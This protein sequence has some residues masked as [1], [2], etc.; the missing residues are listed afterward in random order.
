MKEEKQKPLITAVDFGSSR[1]RMI[2][3]TQNSDGTLH[4]LGT[5]EGVPSG[6][7]HKGTIQNS[8]GASMQL[9][10][11][12]L[13]LSNRIGVKDVIQS[14]YVSL[15]GRLMQVS[16]VP[17]KRDFWSD[18]YITSR[19]LEEM[20]QESIEKM[21]KTYP[22]MIGFNS[23]AIRY[24]IDGTMQTTP[25]PSTQ[26]VKS[27]QIEYN[28]FFFTKETWEKLR[29]A[30]DRAGIDINSCWAKPIT[31]MTALLPEEESQA[32]SAI[33][34]LGA[35]T[36]TLSVYRN[37]Y[38]T[39]TRVIPFGSDNITKDIQSLHISEA[40]AEKLKKNYGYAAPEYVKKAFNI[41]VATVDIDEPTTIVDTTL[42]AEIIQARLDEILEPLLTD[43]RRDENK[44]ERIYVTGA[45]S[46]LNGL[47]PYLREKTQM[48]VDFGSHADWLDESTED[49]YYKPEYASL[50]GTLALAAEYQK[51][52]FD[53]MTK[54]PISKKKWGNRVKDKLIDIFSE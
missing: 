37:N 47:I 9:K 34:D 16:T 42:I 32:G 39:F 1:L 41:R 36:T 6:Y 54:T 2:T 44:V 17:V 3:A 25:P 48:F 33:I 50:V 23:E 15:S 7:I 53:S 8:S 31:L 18:T 27:L 14:I 22:D 46:M 12:L 52:H 28:V 24:I 51:S 29:G 20:Q 4:I 26:K 45:G 21:S 19:L 11:L 10:R 49:E 13:L 30:T 5:E 35:Q 38:C 43:L 40:S